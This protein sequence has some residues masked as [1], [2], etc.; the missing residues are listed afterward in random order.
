MRTVVVFGTSLMAS[1]IAA[2]LRGCTSVE[3]LQLDAAVPGALNELDGLKPD[4][5]VLDLSVAQP[6]L[7]SHLLCM[8]PGLFLIGADPA[9]EEMLVFSSCPVR[10]LSPDALVQLIEKNHCLERLS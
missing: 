2:A 4:V 7:I 3:T 8:H 1:G 10:V 6:E 5:V 9:S